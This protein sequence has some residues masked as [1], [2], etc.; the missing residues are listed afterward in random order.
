MLKDIDLKE[1]SEISDT[2]PSFISIY[3]NAKRND[4]E[5]FLSRREKE[6]LNALSEEKELKQIF[7]KNME[8]IRE[9]LTAGRKSEQAKAF[10]IFSSVPKNFFESYF[11]PIEVENQL[12]VDTSPYIRPLAM[13]QE[14]WES[15]A[16]V[17]LDHSNAKLYIISSAV[18]SDTK[19]MHKDIMNKHKKGGCSQ[20]RFQRLRK[21]A[22]DQFFKEVSEYLEDLLEKE[23]VRRIILAGPGSAKKEFEE[24]LPDHLK[25]KI[26]ATIDEDL[27]VPEGRLLSDSLKDFFKKEREEENEMVQDLR[28]EILKGGLVTYGID[29]TLRAVTEGRAELLLINMGKKAKGWKCERCDIFKLGHAEKCESCG[30]PVYTVDVVEEI[31]E[32]SANMGTILEFV[33]DDEF[34]EELGGVAAF[35]RY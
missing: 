12:V 5:K 2:K 3:L 22:I 34:L 17:L 26:I 24:Y 4:A 20:M 29:E 31:I 9:F 35:L 30:N 25:E 28:A 1:L 13:L 15:F 18:I 23:K 11:L 7:Q 16:I 19:K 32:A 14:E 21:G 8:D 27:D 10:A 6:C 33:M